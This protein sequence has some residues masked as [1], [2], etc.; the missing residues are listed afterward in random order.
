MGLPGRRIVSATGE[1]A[2]H[3]LHNLL[4][5]DIEKLPQEEIRYAALLTPQG[6]IISDMFVQ[7]QESGFLLDL[8][9]SKADDVLKKL[10]LY[11]LRAKV[12]LADATATHHVRAGHEGDA[13]D[14]RLAS[15]GGR[16]IVEGTAVEDDAFY[17]T[18][19][20][21]LGVPEGGADF[22]YNESF[23]HEACLD[24][25]NGIDFKKG[26][27]VGQEIV[28]RMQHRGTARTRIVQMAGTSPL[29]AIGS[30]ISAGGK[31]IGR[32]G[33]SHGEKGIALARLDRIVDAQNAG[34]PIE[35]EG[36]ALTLSLP[37]WATYTWPQ[38]DGE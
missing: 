18:Y 22:V 28:S 33:S 7:R 20:V 1:D 12:E 16:R 38:G 23:P 29:P 34:H 17:H 24:Q 27:Y 2:A 10:T 25:L 14:P 9:A 26:C 35:S 32:M 15:L 30:A 8:P 19:R 21:A 6:K 11:K 37:Q 3:F 13:P 5:Q 31:T 36:V 4:T